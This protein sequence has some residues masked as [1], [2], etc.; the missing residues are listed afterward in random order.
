MNIVKFK[1]DKGNKYKVIIDNNEYILY[2][3]TIIKFGLLSKKNINNDV[4]NEVIKY[5]E[6]LKYYYLVLKYINK[7]L[8]CKKE[9]INYLNK[10]ELDNDTIN[11]IID[12]LNHDG[13]LDEYLYLKSFINDKLNLSDDGPLKIKISLIKL[14]FTVD[15]ID[16]V[17]NTILEDV[18]M[19]KRVSNIVDKKIRLNNNKGKYYLKRK[20]L[21]DLT[22]LGY[23]KEIILDVLNTINFDDSN[24]YK[25][26]KEKAINRFSK[27]YSGY[28]LENKVNNYLY[29]K[30]FSCG[31]YYEE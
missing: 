17:M 20:I 1:K 5:N 29:R 25:K 31:E 4:F 19:Y 10:Y 7:R 9:I 26:E 23:N 2:D 13:Y 14:G 3:D 27:K 18:D 11:V 30:G 8:R 21:L 28:E 15:S 22:N 6:F 12:K 16:E 24:I